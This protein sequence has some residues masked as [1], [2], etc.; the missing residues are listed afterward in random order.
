MMVLERNIQNLTAEEFDVLIIGGGIFGACAAWD[1]TLRGMK[2]A[3]IE[4]NDFCSGVSANSFKIVHG[5]M[6]YLQHAD[7]KRL[8]SSC[9]ERSAMLRIAPHL[10]Q[11]LPIMVPTYGYGKS[12]KA[13]LATGLYLYDFLTLDRNKKISD[14]DNHIPW[15]RLLSRE[16]VLNEYPELDPDGLTGGV[17]FCDGRMYNPTRLVLSFIQSAASKGACVANY[18]E[19]NEFINEDGQITG[20]H[21]YD[22]HSNCSLTIRAKTV[23][24]ASGPWAERLLKTNFKKEIQGTY[25][26]DACFVIKRRFKS[27]YTIA[28]QGRTKD[29]DALLSR[30]ARHLF[31]SPWRNY[32][33][34]GVWHVV[35]DKHPDK[36]SVSGEDL[37]SFMDEINWAYP[38]LNLKLSDVTMWNAGLVPFGENEPGSEHLSYGKRSHVLDHQQTDNLKGLVTLIGVRYTMGRS[39]SAKAVDLIQ[40]K[41]GQPVRQAPT[42]Y[43]PVYGG[44]FK[45]FDDLVLQIED[46]FNHC[47][48]TDVNQAIAHNYGNEYGALNTLVQENTELGELIE[49]STVLKAEVIHAIRN[50]MAIKLSDIVFRRTDLATGKHPGMN[51]LKEC[52]ALASN[53]L[54]WSE[55]QC[56]A[57]LQSALQC[58][59]DFK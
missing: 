8:R 55:E 17:V 39:D 14:P 33:L 15:T 40:Q 53:E 27:D 13:F 32:T 50:E 10:V 36:V 7:I 6:R 41:L 26:R 43:Q 42:D 3:L 2:V 24:N 48:D 45:K 56:E 11:P 44:N 54:N 25:S 1:A 34:V 29:P 35:T 20:V 12:G 47:L 16:E 30:P 22:H 37:E 31:M 18:I 58:F 59:P 28:I 52:A 57:E 9:H 19:A 38:Q 23:L 49:G 46:Q 21:A 4:K 5:G 51:A